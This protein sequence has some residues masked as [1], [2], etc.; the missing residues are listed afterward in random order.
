MPR[1]HTSYGKQHTITYQMKFDEKKQ[2]FAPQS[3]FID[4][5]WDVVSL[6]DRI[7]IL[8]YYPKISGMFRSVLFRLFLVEQYK[9]L[10]WIDFAA[11]VIWDVSSAHTHTHTHTSM[12]PEFR[13]K[14]YLC[15]FVGML[16]GLNLSN[17]AVNI[18]SRCS[19]LK[20]DNV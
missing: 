16:Q 18:G 12:L 13:Y 9:M 4:I 1:V 8:K 15:H 7:F 6:Y 19:Q 3:G 14:V 10:N 11:Q 5:S 2:L 17:F 20:I